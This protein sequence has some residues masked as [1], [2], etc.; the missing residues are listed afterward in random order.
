MYLIHQS[1]C[2][3]NQFIMSYLVSTCNQ[4]IIKKINYTTNQGAN[5]K[6]QSLTFFK[7][8]KTGFE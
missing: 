8:V 3:Q 1:I 6:Q 5:S 7:N 2:L 4:P